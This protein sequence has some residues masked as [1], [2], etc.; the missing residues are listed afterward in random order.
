MWAHMHAVWPRFQYIG[1]FTAT[2]QMVVDQSYWQ[3]AIAGK[4]SSCAK[5]SSS[6]H[7]AAAKHVPEELLHLWPRMQA[8]KRCMLPTMQGYFLASYLYM[9]IVF[10]LPLAAGCFA[11]AMDLPV[12]VDEA[13]EGLVLPA[14]AYVIMGKSG[15]GLC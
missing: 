1:W 8:H 9:S 6:L 4:A 12:S 3:S 13:F 5:V 2:A 11:L 15:K 10:V 14:S 7:A